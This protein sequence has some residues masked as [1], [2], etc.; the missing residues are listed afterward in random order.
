MEWISWWHETVQDSQKFVLAEF[1]FQ[2]VNKQKCLTVCR[3]RW[4]LNCG[5]T[6]FYSHIYDDVVEGSIELFIIFLFGKDLSESWKE[7]HSI[8]LTAGLT[9]VVFLQNIQKTYLGKPFTDCVPIQGSPNQ[10]PPKGYWA[11][12]NDQLESP[13]LTEVEN[14]Y[15]F[16]KKFPEKR[17]KIYKPSNC[18]YRSLLKT[19]KTYCNCYPSYIGND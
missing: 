3:F 1:A 17:A 13:V 4:I 8:P 9:P 18:I 6:L 16:G 2:S 10:A 19:I 12:I 7:I 15:I 5:K 14:T 11:S